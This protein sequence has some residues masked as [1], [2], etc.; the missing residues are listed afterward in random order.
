[1]ATN[2]GSEVH[3]GGLHVS[4]NEVFVNFDDRGGGVV[5][6]PG[7]DG[8]NHDHVV[9]EGVIIEGGRS[10]CN[11]SVG[12]VSQR[13]QMVTS[14]ELNND[15][16]LV[17]FEDFEVD[18]VR[19]SVPH[20]GLLLAGTSVRVRNDDEFAV[21]VFRQ[22]FL[23]PEHLVGTGCSGDLFVSQVVV[24]EGIQ[25]QNGDV[26]VKVESVVTTLVKG[27]LNLGLLRV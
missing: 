2:S 21:S 9:V 1:M 15:A 4:G 26:V 25:G 3:V 16:V 17:V 20:S 24:V 23:E 10:V 6:E 22:L 13:G 14:S 18:S 8:G 7:R 19:V 11:V 27:F 5:V 12:V